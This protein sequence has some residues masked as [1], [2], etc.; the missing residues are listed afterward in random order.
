MLLEVLGFLA[1]KKGIDTINAH[2]SSQDVG[3]GVYYDNKGKLRHH[4]KE[5]MMYFE[6]GDTV[7]GNAKDGKIFYNKTLERA[8]INENNAI[9]NGET[10]FLRQT[11]NGSGRLGNHSIAGARYCKAGGPYNIFY[12]IRTIEYS[13]SNFHYYGKYYMDMNCNI[14]CPTDETNKNDKK[15]YGN[16][17]SSV[18]NN[19]MAIVNKRIKD[20]IIDPWSERPIMVGDCEKYRYKDTG[21]KMANWR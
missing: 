4:G 15:I 9:K 17:C 14:I 6:N 2:T 10:F 18:E 16:Q 11:D 13:K 12:I 19:V 5:A 8:K 3:N 21:R 1:C 20:K 7:Y